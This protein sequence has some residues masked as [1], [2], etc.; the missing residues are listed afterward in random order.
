MLEKVTIEILNYIIN[1]LKFLIIKILHPLNFNYEIRNKCSF[2]S[3]IKLRN[4]GKIIIKKNVKIEKNTLISALNG[5]K[6][7]LGENSFLN[8]N[9]YIVCHEQINIGKN[10][11]IGPNVVI[12]DHDH[13]FSNNFIESKKFKTKKIEIGDGVWI[14]ANCVI[15]KGT[16]IGTNCVIAAGSIVFGEIPSNTIYIQKKN[17]IIKKIGEKNENINSNRS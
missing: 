9:C 17:K 13:D 12:V 16:K 1:N 4:K 8:R 3:E 14:G 2:L 10:V 15:L 6:L 7:N 5:G 11:I